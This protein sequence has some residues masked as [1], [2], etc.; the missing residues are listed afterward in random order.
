[1]AIEQPQFGPGESP[2]SIEADPDEGYSDVNDGVQPLILMEHI[3][4]S[5]KQEGS[6]NTPMAMDIQ[7]FPDMQTDDTKEYWD[8]EDEEEDEGDFAL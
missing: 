7:V 5:F 8:N 3:P 2:E 4:E 1:M 6:L